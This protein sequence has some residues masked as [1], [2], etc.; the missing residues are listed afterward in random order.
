MAVVANASEKN[1]VGK[2]EEVSCGSLL[3]LGGPGGLEDRV[4]TDSNL[5]QPTPSPPPAIRSG[6]EYRAR[7]PPNVGAAQ[8]SRNS[9][10]SS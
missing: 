10:S 2:E 9:C 6:G 5:T 3:F 8:R 4:R 7:P 1:Q